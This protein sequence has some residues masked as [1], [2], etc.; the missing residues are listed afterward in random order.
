MDTRTFMTEEQILALQALLKHKSTFNNH[1]AEVVEELYVKLIVWSRDTGH[2]WTRIYLT[3]HVPTKE[4]Q[5]YAD[6]SDIEY[7]QV[8][9]LSFDDLLNF[10]WEIEDYKS[11]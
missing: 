11:N 9:D 8:K 2:M 7:K 1:L 5:D 3:D 4:E 6:F 10:L